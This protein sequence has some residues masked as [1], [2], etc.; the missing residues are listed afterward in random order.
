MRS[1]CVMRSL[2][3]R[4]NNTP[5]ANSTSA[6]RATTAMIAKTRGTRRALSQETSGK[7]RI[8]RNAE[9]RIVLTGPLAACRPATMM[10]TAAVI[11]RYRGSLLWV[12]ARGS[13][14]SLRGGLQE[15][16]RAAGA[17]RSAA[18]RE[19]FCPAGTWVPRLVIG[20]LALAG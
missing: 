16:Y 8:A 20:K 4:A 11:H 7:L 12:A 10:T 9:T 13:T 14:D 6:S 19:G 17:V 3:T 5:I 18:S 1:G 15:L 2:I